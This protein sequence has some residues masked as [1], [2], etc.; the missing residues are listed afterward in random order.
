[1]VKNT[2]TQKVYSVSS[3][4]QALILQDTLAHAG[5]PVKLVKSHHDARIDLVVES[6]YV[7]DAQNIFSSTSLSVECAR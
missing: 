1:M 3:M 2:S 7:Y 5:I 4:I 6:K